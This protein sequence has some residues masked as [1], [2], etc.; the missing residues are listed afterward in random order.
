MSPYSTHMRSVG[1][2]SRLPTCTPKQLLKFITAAHTCG[3]AHEETGASA[4]MNPVCSDAIHLHT[5]V[6]MY[7]LTS[8]HLYV[9]L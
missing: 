6:H 5:H 8:T 1:L 3:H 9:A 4:D 7:I 2:C